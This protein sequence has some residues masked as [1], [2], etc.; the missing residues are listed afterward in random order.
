MSSEPETIQ[1]ALPKAAPRL[2]RARHRS[3]NPE[4]G[5]PEPEPFHHKLLEP[6][7]S[8]IDFRQQPPAPLSDE[9]NLERRG[10]IR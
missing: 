4:P 2:A 5:I 1:L 9:G 8:S 10:L 3:T 6:F 7:E